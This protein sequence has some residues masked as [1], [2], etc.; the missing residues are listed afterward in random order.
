[1]SSNAGEI[2]PDFRPNCGEN[3]DYS[4][5]LL[6][7]EEVVRRVAKDTSAPK[8]LDPIVLQWHTFIRET[9]EKD[10]DGAKRKISAR[11]EELVTRLEEAQRK[12]LNSGELEQRV[13]D[14]KR[15][16]KALVERAARRVL[17]VFPREDDGL[18]D[19]ADLVFTLWL[20]ALEK[21]SRKH[22]ECL[23]LLETTLLACSLELQRLQTGHYP[24]D[25]DELGEVPRDPFVG[26]TV[27]YRRFARPNGE[28][29][30]LAAAGP[31]NDAAERIRVFAEECD[32]DPEKFAKRGFGEVDAFTFGTFRR[33]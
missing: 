18:V 17:G 25:L 6:G 28:G 19:I 23:L 3:L 7:L 22:A 30:V 13:A 11:W 32:F 8:E 1:L 2:V 5:T 26:G 15:G 10:F 27:R 14:L 12:P 16:A 21:A 33:R 20:P 9:L 4:D 24:A 29:Y 31:R